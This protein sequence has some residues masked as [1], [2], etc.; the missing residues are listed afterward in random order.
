M[1]MLVIPADPSSLPVPKPIVGGVA[2]AASYDERAISPGE[3]IYIG[4][5][6]FG[7]TSLTGAQL[8]PDGG[9]LTTSLAGVSVLINGVLA[10]MVYQ[11]N[12]AIAAIVPYEAGLATTAAVQ[13]QVQGVRSDPFLIPVTTEVPA[14]FSSNASGT[15]QGAILNQDLSVNSSANP[16]NPGDI[17]V[18]YATGEGVTYP[19][20]VDGRL[21]LDIRP[22]PAQ[23]CAV[24]IG[25]QAASVSYCGAAP[26]YASGLM[27]INVQIPSSTSPGNAPVAL[28]IGGVSSTAAVTVAVK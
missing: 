8:T 10:P 25:G 3:F 24:T 4:G 23:A 20:G 15:G 27:Q 12:E 21:A 7:P 19:P 5:T 28:S 13:V 11:T 18:L 2:N 26:Y 6:N 1:T 22:A 16:A 9:Y 17:V 14:L